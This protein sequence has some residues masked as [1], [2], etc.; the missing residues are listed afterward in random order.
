MKKILILVFATFASLNFTNAAPSKVQQGPLTYGK[1][2]SSS[3]LM[4]VEGEA[5]NAIFEDMTRVPV[6][7]IQRL[8]IKVGKSVTCFRGREVAKW[9]TTCYMAF[10]DLT[11][12]LID[13][14]QRMTKP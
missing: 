10:T 3:A 6:Q 5:A 11:L 9:K 2:D 1:M 12:G 13:N 14:S 8:Q 7:Q 4:A